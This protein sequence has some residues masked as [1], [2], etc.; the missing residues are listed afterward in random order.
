[1]LL[2]FYRKV[3]SK[4]WHCHHSTKNKKEDSRRNA[5]CK[6]TFK[7]E[8]KKLCRNTIKNDNFLSLD[9]PLTA[10][11]TLSLKHSH[12]ISGAETLKMLRVNK[13]VFSI[14]LF[15]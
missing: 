13:E 12:N 5:A 10:V 8:I 2:L 14:L 11:V 1:M 4:A 6:A 15:K 7:I 3:F 9:P